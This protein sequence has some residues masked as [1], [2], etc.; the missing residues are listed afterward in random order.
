MKFT[1]ETARKAGSR[2]TRKG[3]PNKATAETRT[4]LDT[5]VSE[6]FEKYKG[7]LEEL[8]GKE[9][10]TAYH[11]LLEYVLPKLQRVET[12]SSLDLDSLTEKQLDQVIEAVLES[13]DNSVNVLNL[14]SGINP[15]ESNE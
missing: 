5:L 9:Y 3:V 12:S 4:R 15:D 11:Q 7:E 8:T 2:S 1:P 10:I 6:Q 14:G 13:S